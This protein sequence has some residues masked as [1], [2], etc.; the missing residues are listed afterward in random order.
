LRLATFNYWV[1]SYYG[2]AP[3]A[4]GGAPV[5]GSLPRINKTPNLRYALLFAAGVA[6]LLNSRPYEG[7]IVSAVSAIALIYSLS[8]HP[9]PPRPAIWRFALAAVTL[10]AAVALAMAYY[11]WRVF[12]SPFALPGH[13][14]GGRLVCCSAAPYRWSVCSPLELSSLPARLG[15]AP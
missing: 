15:T 1:N 11:N 2:G 6:I 4:I 9:G 3:G 5:L 13:Q 14:E 10:L 7:L 12:G 8:H